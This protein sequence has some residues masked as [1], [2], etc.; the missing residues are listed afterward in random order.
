[1]IAA[2]DNN[3]PIKLLQYSELNETHGIRFSRRHLYTLESEHKFPKRVPL[4]EN[5]VAG[6]KSRNRRLDQREGRLPGR[7]IPRYRN[8]SHMLPNP[9]DGWGGWEAGLP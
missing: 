2:N 5:R 8:A 6:S 7:L 3:K 1:M 9:G 4:G